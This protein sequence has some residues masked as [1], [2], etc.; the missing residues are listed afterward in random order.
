MLRE[1]TPRHEGNVERDG[2]SIHFQVFG[3][4]P[5]AILLLPT[6]SIVHSDFWRHQVP[7]FAERFTVVA[8][9]GL[10]NGLSDRPVAPASYED[11]LFADDA[12]AVL[13]AVGI[14][15]A[16]A[17]SVSQGG[18]WGL[19]LAAVAP[20]RV[21]GSV[22]IAPNVP[23]SEPHPDRA[24][25]FAAFDTELDEYVGWLKFNSHYW[26]RD[27]PDFLSFFF[28]QC[29]TEPNSDEE[30]QHFVGMG[31]E[32]TPEVIDA[33]VRAPGIDGVTARELAG[34]VR[35]PSLVIH[36]DADAITPTARGI[37]LAQ[38]LGAEL[39]VLQGSG[40]EPQCRIPHAVNPI[41]D[42]FLRKAGFT[43]TP[44]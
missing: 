25:A 1:L 3:N 31:L 44:D 6:W 24:E 39:H 18:C 43:D 10:G 11:R 38:L 4:G 21:A 35:A 5:K 33:T 8:F 29:F 32:T 26:R 16:M 30:I 28:A 34:A 14:E 7:Y 17:M 40:H 22:F 2:C 41:I 15:R 42:D 19:V 37:T 36:G 23:L 9:D 27:W 20:E 13:D 12:I